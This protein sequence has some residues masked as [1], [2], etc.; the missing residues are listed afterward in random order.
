MS[1]LNV[2]SLFTNI[3]LEETVNTCINQLFENTHT[4][5]GFTKSDFK[6]MLCL[7]TKESYFIFN[8][9]LNKQTDGVAMGSPFGPSLAN[10]FL[11]YNEKNWSKSCPQGF[12]PVFYRRYVDI[13]FVLFKSNDRLKYFQELLISCHINMSFSMETE[14]QNK[15]SFL[16]I[17]IIREQGKF[18]TTIYRKPTVSGVYSNFGSFLL[19]I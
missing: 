10:T 8:G 14:I 3:P 11:S 17:E 13:I 16:D 12:K 1:S 9:L 7:A 15:F 18:S 4:V 2:D 5:E 6:Q 19:F